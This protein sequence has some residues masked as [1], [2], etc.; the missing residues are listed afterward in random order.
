MTHPSLPEGVENSREVTR[1]EEMGES[2]MKGKQKLKYQAKL[3][4]QVRLLR[5]LRKISSTLG[6]MKLFSGTIQSI[7]SA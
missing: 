3:E 5:V 4:F 6:I 1:E 7:T 2:E